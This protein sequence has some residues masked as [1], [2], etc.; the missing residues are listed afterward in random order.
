MTE[1]ITT[2]YKGNNHVWPKFHMNIS[3]M[4]HYESL[5]SASRKPIVMAIE[6]DN[7]SP[8]HSGTS[9]HISSQ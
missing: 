1:K 3:V 5:C 2:I 7:V 4:S 9:I 8:E 6:N